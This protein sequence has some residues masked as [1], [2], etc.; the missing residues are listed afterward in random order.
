MHLV[1]KNRPTTLLICHVKN[2]IGAY[3]NNIAT[4]IRTKRSSVGVRLYKL[5]IKE[6]NLKIQ[7]ITFWT[8]AVLAL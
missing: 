1:N 2:K 6:V 4:K 5:I 3:E 7:N 8:D